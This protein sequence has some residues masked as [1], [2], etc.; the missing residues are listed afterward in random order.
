M[1]LLTLQWSHCSWNVVGWSTEVDW[2]HVHCFLK[3]LS[4]MVFLSI[5]YE[6]F[7]NRE[8]TIFFFSFPG[9]LLWRFEISVPKTLFIDTKLLLMI[10]ASFELAMLVVFSAGLAYNVLSLIQSDYTFKGR[11]NIGRIQKKVIFDNFKYWRRWFKFLDNKKSNSIWLF[12]RQ[13]QALNT[14]LFLGNQLWQY[15]L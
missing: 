13:D 6:L 7:S 12:V 4:G 14:N 10:V 9:W 2:K 11:R 5:N 3:G 8:H 15:A 1:F